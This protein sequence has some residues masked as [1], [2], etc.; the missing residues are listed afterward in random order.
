MTQPY[1]IIFTQLENNPDAFTRLERRWTQLERQSERPFFLSWRWIGT[2]LAGLEEMPFLAEIKTEDGRDIALGLFCLNVEVRHHVLKLRQLVLQST[3]QVDRDSM[4]IEYN[5]LLCVRDHE[6]AVWQSLLDFLN[7]QQSPH[8][9][10][11]IIPGATHLQEEMTTQ[12]MPNTYRRAEAGSA[13]VDLAA[14]RRDGVED[15]DS[16]LGTLSK[17]TRTQ[18]RRSLKLYKNIGP[19]HIERA[20]DGDEGCAFFSQLGV[21]HQEKWRARGKTSAMGNPIYTDFHHRLIRSGIKDH[22]VELVKI[23]A[24]TQLIGW[25]YNFIDRGQVLFYCS[26]FVTEKNNKLKPGLTAHSLMIEDHLQKG[27]LIYD[28]MGGD[29]RYKLS[30]GQAGPQIVSYALQRPKMSLRL[31]HFARTT[32]EKLRE[33]SVKG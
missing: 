18:I 13:Y 23:S 20:R 24:G 4:T 33:K 31:E 11:I 32:R 8:W 9:D 28:F 7:G 1:L 27:Q 14:L 5:N 2:W 3:G 15:C 16:Y 22:S 19:L 17:N 21:L 26:G 12:I 30:L 6:K 29:D 25:L 10:E